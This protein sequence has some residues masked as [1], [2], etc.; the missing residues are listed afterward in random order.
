MATLAQAFQAGQ[1]AQRPSAEVTDRSSA[2]SIVDDPPPPYSEGELSVLLA[3]DSRMNARCFSSFNSRQFLFIHG[4]SKVDG[5]IGLLR[6]LTFSDP[7]TSRADCP[8]TL[9]PYCLQ[10]RAAVHRRTQ[11][12]QHCDS[13]AYSMC[14]VFII[15]HSETSKDIAPC[16][17]G[18]LGAG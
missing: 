2:W 11:Y 16:V 14:N 8:S 15:A 5:S 4:V 10:E 17:E 1:P 6:P 12:G 7:H 3:K 13:V 9:S 18:S